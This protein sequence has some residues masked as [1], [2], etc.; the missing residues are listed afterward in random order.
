MAC[1]PGHCPNCE[2]PLM[3][4]CEFRA[5]SSADLEAEMQRQLARERERREIPLV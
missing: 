5:L 3:H 1:D 2:L 4:T